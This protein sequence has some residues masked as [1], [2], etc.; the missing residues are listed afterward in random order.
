VCCCDLSLVSW[1]IWSSYLYAISHIHTQQCQKF[2]QVIRLTKLWSLVLGLTEPSHHMS[3]NTT[4]SI[5]HMTHTFHVLHTIHV[6]QHYIPHD[7][8]IP[9]LSLPLNV[10]VSVRLTRHSISGLPI[11]VGY[12]IQQQKSPVWSPHFPYDWSYI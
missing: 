1:L 2:I 4:C 12:F 10:Y 7:P 11:S 3:H 5:H 6:P 9:Q 8:H